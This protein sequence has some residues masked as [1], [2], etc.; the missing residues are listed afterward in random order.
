MRGIAVS[1]LLLFAAAS[2]ARADASV[3]PAG[4]TCRLTFDIVAENHIGTLA[5]GGNL[6]GTL[7]FQVLSAWRQDTE[8]VSYTTDGRLS[9]GAAGH[10]S[11][12]G[13]IGYVHVVRAP[14]IADYISIDVSGAHGDL[15][16]ETTYYDPMLVTL[17]APAGTLPNSEIPATDA[18]WQ[19][20]SKR[21]V[22]QVHTPTAAQTFHGPI[23][24][25]TGTCN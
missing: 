3:S 18:R 2:G 7:H 11:V 8:T 25:L 16:G 17:Y 10:G 14:A 12:G 6:T 22:F 19:A 4:L 21:R 23:T 15:G 20:L 9:A 1:A 5:N 13:K 24:R